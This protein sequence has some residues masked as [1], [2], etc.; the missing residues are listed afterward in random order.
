[1]ILSH[2]VSSPPESSWAS[3]SFWHTPQMVISWCQPNLHSACTDPQFSTCYRWPMIAL[4][5]CSFTRR[6]REH[7]D[8][9][10]CWPFRMCS[11]LVAHFCAVSSESGSLFLTG[12]WAHSV[13]GWSPPCLV[14]SIMGVS[15][16]PG[17]PMV[18]AH[19]M[20]LA[21]IETR[22]SSRWI[23]WAAPAFFDLDLIAGLMLIAMSEASHYRFGSCIPLDL[24]SLAAASS[25]TWTW[26][27]L[28]QHCYF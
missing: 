22:F 21:G 7:T 17:G 16:D 8:S 25:L 18:T 5:R 20:I 15:V 27:S 14:S 1:M 28:K 2:P 26:S 3:S 4:A 11:Y 9:T 19:W 23:Y 12:L 10:V 24:H 13:W 6:I